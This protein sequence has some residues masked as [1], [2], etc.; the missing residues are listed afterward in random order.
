MRITW[1]IYAKYWGGSLAQARSAHYSDEFGS[2]LLRSN[3]DS[4]VAFMQLRL[5]GDRADINFFCHFYS[6]I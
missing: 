5:A 1:L 4:H 2:G 6:R 3:S